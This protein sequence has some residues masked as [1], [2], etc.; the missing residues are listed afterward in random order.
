MKKKR[1]T[2][3]RFCAIA[4]VMSVYPLF[5]LVFT[6]SHVFKADFGGGRH[7]PLDAYRHA[8]ASALVSYTLG[9]WAV[10]AVTSVLEGNGKDSHRMDRHNNRIGAAIGSR[11]KS[12]T[13]IEPEV[14]RSVV[15]GEVDT[16]ERSQITWLRKSQ[17]REGHLW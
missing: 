16:T 5:V 1:K 9:E 14:H 3:R 15:N 11:V 10:H 17:W 8:L 6:W 7:G 12:F 2:L 13:E 4:A